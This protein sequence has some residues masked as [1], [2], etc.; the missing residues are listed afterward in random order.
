MKTKK[1]KICCFT[2]TVIFQKS[3]VSDHGS[4]DNDTKTIYINMNYPEQVQRETL[5]HEILHACLH[6]FPNFGKEMR[7]HDQEEEIIRYQSPIEVQVYRDNKWA[8]EFIFG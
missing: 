4:T 1:L 5:H 2:F 7:A 3:D 8:K 6:D